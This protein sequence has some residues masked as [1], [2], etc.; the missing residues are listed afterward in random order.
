MNNLEFVLFNLIFFS[1]GQLTTKSFIKSESKYS[2]RIFQTPIFIFYPLIGIIILSLTVFVVNFLFPIEFIKNFLQLLGIFILLYFFKINLNSKFTFFH[3]FNLI[4]VPFILAF[5]TYGI[6]FHYDAEAYHLTTQAWILNSKITLGL[7]KF[8]IW[9]GHSSLYEYLNSVLSFQGNF[10]YQHYL[11]LI[12]FSLFINF[13][14]YHLLKNENKLFFNS[15][16]FLFFFA[17]FDNFGVGGGSNGFLQIQMVGKPDVAVGVVYLIAALFLIYNIYISPPDYSEFL[18]LLILLTYLIQVRV[19]SFS[20]IFLIIPFLIKNYKIV[21]PMLFSKYSIL[22]IF[23]NIIWLIKNLINSACLF[24][25]LQQSCITSLS[26]NVESTLNN[27]NKTYS[28]WVYAYKFDRSFFIFLDNWFNAGNNWQQ[29]PNLVISLVLLTIIRFVFFKKEKNDYKS[30]S[31]YI[32]FIFLVSLYFTFHI[33]YLFGFILLIVSVLSFNLNLK[34]SFSWIKNTKI[35]YLLL[36]FLTVSIP[37][38]HSYNYF[39]SNPGYYSLEID[40]KDFEYIENQNGYGIIALKNKCYDIY[41]CST[42]QGNS[43]NTV[44]NLEQY[45]GSYKIFIED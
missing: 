10:I 26:W 44:I 14:G 43:Q 5:S 3:V 40:Y 8:F 4:I 32:S 20:L 25:P 33:R 12:F 35:I 39:F 37:R 13:I 36:I 2:K 22:I 18:F 27:I 41:Y 21:K 45:F 1:I 15:S 17:I 6:K 16:L 38:G 23:Y 42:F 9:H 11:N 28:T 19:I 34:T 29:V 7:S 24:F 30:I 31:I